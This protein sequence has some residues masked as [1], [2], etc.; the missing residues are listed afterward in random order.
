[1]VENQNRAPRFLITNASLPLPEGMERVPLDEQGLALYAP[2]DTDRFAGSGFRVWVFGYVLPRYSVPDGGLRG[3]ELVAALWHERREGVVNVL[4]GIF[5]VVVNQ[6]TETFLFNDH[7]ALFETFTARGGSSLSL[8]TSIELLLLAGHHPGVSPSRLAARTLINRSL[9]GQTVFANT[10]RLKGAATLRFH[11]GQ[12]TESSYWSYESLLPVNG[13]DPDVEVAPFAELLTDNFRRFN[14]ATRPAHHLITLTGGKDGRTALAVLMANGITPQGI[15]YGNPGSMDAVYAQK[16]AQ[17]ARLPHS[18]VTPPDTGSY[19]NQM[20]EQVVATGNPEISFHRAHRL[21]AMQQL[22][23][24]TSGRAALYTGYM[25]GEMMMGIF[26][27]NLIFTDFL[28]QHWRTASVRAETVLAQGFHRTE[29]LDLEG[30]TE[31]LRELKCLDPSIPPAVQRFHAL[32]EIGVP[33]HRQDVVLAQAVLGFPYPFF[34]DVDLLERVFKSRFNLFYTSNTTVN[35]LRRYGLYY[36][37]LQLQHRL[38]PSLDQVAF[39]KRGAYSTREYLRGPV[40]WSVVKSLRYITHRHKYPSSYT[41]G[42]SF[43]EFL[44]NR[45][46]QLLADTNHPVHPFF[47]LGAALHNL[48]SVDGN[49][50]EAAVHRFSFPVLLAAQLSQFLR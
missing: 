32:F 41:Y 45:Y 8:A 22:A 46:Q 29:R 36:L 1:M 35:P 15:T 33:H 34:L 44:A 49:Q 21:Y 3:A 20:L 27:D 11:R 42:I 13:F 24:A 43:R 38:A 39:G 4:K 14:E 2:P 9:P 30:A 18:I 16:L 5:F 26:F 48:R 6:G 37:N 7:L 40:Y 12:V 10:N 50:G 47:D 23:A 19:F 31:L 17:A 25:A 28:T